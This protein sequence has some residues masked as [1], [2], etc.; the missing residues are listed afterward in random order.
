M[1]SEA[2]ELEVF[3]NLWEDRRNAELFKNIGRADAEGDRA[4]AFALEALAPMDPVEPVEPMGAAEAA[5]AEDAEAEK[6]YKPT[7]TIHPGKY[8]PSLIYPFCSWHDEPE[9]GGNGKHTFA[10]A[11]SG[12]LLCGTKGCGEIKSYDSCGIQDM[13][14]GFFEWMFEGSIFPTV[15]ELV[16]NKAGTTK[17]DKDLDGILKNRDLSDVDRY[18]AIHDYINW[19]WRCSQELLF[20]KLPGAHYSL[21]CR[22]RMND[23]YRVN[24]AA[25]WGAR[26]MPGKAIEARS[27]ATAFHAGAFAH[28]NVE[29]AAMKGVRYRRT[30]KG[31]GHRKTSRRYRRQS[32]H[33]TRKHRK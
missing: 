25:P 3:Y 19:K 22:T 13:N 30:L 9:P 15:E 8:P 2:S 28:G 14:Y 7:I 5:G 1:D 16:G 12:I 6:G 23:F 24:M 33:R 26:R 17:G 32:K 4:R 18:Y 27:A 31:G 10:Y 20:I 11:R 21:I 29:E